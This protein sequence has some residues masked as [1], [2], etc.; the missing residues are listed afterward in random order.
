M[1]K[2][3]VMELPTCK[4]LDI[5]REELEGKKSLQSIRATVSELWN[6]KP[7]DMKEF[8]YNING[9]KWRGIIYQ[10]RNSLMGTIVSFFDKELFIVRGY[11]KLRYAD[12]T[13]VKGKHV[14]CQEK[15][16]GTNL[17][18]FMLPDGT[19]MGKTRLVPRWDLQT[20]PAAKRGVSSWKD[21][22]MKVQDGRTYERIQRVLKDGYLVFGELYGAL[23][24]TDFIQ[25]SVPIDFKVFDIVDM[26][27]MR[28][29]P[30]SKTKE[31]TWLNGL[32]RV[33]EIWSGE[34]T[35]KEIERLE[36]ELKKE[37][38]PD[39]MEGLVAKY[40]DTDLKD[41]LMAKLKC[42]EIK[43]K[44]WEHART[45]I[46]KSIIRKAIRKVLENYPELEKIE[47]IEPKVREELLE[48]VT[49]E[50][51]ENSIDRVKAEIRRYLMPT[52]EDLKDVVKEIM[53]GLQ[54][55][56]INL[57]DKRVVLST[58]H[59]RIGEIDGKVLYRIYQKVKAELKGEKSEMS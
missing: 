57:D 49:P 48:D 40:Y 12:E 51:Y 31:I 28:F 3:N 55:A 1:K 44:C 42:E 7:A 4:R 18:I 6:A 41:E 33:K 36:F 32:R 24:P 2:V 14:V 58:I 8:S 26:K 35:V 46:P 20:A 21:L 25:Y 13:E 30:W 10:K 17:G 22:F 19:I 5:L 11:P 43:E 47:D 34:L 23:N 39:G 56:G 15:V 53:E 29:L 16:D 52:P 50:L 27:T 37:V 59:R 9:H 38:K 54:L 45:T